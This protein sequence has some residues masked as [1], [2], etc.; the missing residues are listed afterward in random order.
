MLFCPVDLDIGR[1]KVYRGAPGRQ[2]ITA[3]LRQ[4]CES[5]GHERCVGLLHALAGFGREALAEADHRGR[6]GHVGHSAQGQPSGVFSL[7][8]QVH[9][10]VPA[11]EH[12][13]GERD[14][15]LAHAE[16]ATPLL[17][18]RRRGVNCARDTEELVELSHQVE[19]GPRG[20]TTIGG[21]KTYPRRA[22]LLSVG[23]CYP[24]HQ[25]GAFRS[26]YRSV[27]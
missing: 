6:G 7:V 14:Q 2:L 16:P 1:V 17:Y 27:S 5:L 13:L 4:K 19:A 3:R 20:D 15:Q 23:F 25:T 26:G 9:Q 22:L 10:E 8:V 12:R 24:C 21:A 18:T 11:R